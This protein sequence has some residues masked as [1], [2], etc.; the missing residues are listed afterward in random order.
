MMI[1][2]SAL[3]CLDAGSSVNTWFY[4]VHLDATVIQN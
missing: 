1:L 2:F 4:A 3:K